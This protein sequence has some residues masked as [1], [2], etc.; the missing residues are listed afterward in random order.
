MAIFETPR[1]EPIDHVV[2]ELIA[3]QREQLRFLT[4][5]N[6]K[7]WMGSLR[8][9]ALA[10]AIRNSNSIEGYHVTYDQA[11]A[12][13]ENEA[14]PQEGY[15]ETWLATKGYRDALTYIMQA[16]ADPTFEFS[17]QFLKSLHFIMIGHEIQKY[18]GQWR[19]NNVYVVAS[20]SGETVYEAP[21]P[22]QVNDLVEEL[23]R[24]LKN[25]SKD[26][27]IVRGA[28]AH[29]NLA[30]IHPFKDGNGRMARALQT[31]L[32][33]R[34]GLV[35]P[36]F[37]SIE[38][39]LGD[40]TPEYYQVLAEVGQGRWNPQNSALPWVRFC[41][42]GHYQQGQKIIRRN[43]EYSVIFDKIQKLIDEHKLPERVE[44]PLFDV[45]LGT[46][47]TNS[48]YR[49][50]ANVTEYVASR[51]LKR[52]SELGLIAP[53]GEARGRSYGASPALEKIYL[54]SRVGRVL[55]DV[56]QVAAAVLK[57]KDNDAE[58]RLPGV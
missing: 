30:M 26:S 25:E 24:Y 40:N 52:L 57:A 37:S 11:I 42:K 23:V 38:E 29:L 20:Q 7:R 46:R 55:D 44:I 33:A 31:L 16:A 8:R 14:P 50:E 10:L 9:S 12:A 43:E 39:W 34:D 13:A 22:E 5:S 54:S 19:P 41:L 48:R 35:H 32:I 49:M 47:L 3:R 17:K 15:S 56:Y 18:P 58:P 45:C 51:D 1:P 2:M 6:P 21:D 53:Q 27:S 36:V 4:Q 28:M